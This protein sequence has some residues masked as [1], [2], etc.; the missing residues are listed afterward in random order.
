MAKGQTSTRLCT[1][2]LWLCPQRAQAALEN[3]NVYDPAEGDAVYKSVLNS[4]RSASMN[5]YLFEARRLP[6]QHAGCAALPAEPVICQTWESFCCPLVTT[7][8]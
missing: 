1:L 2:S 3:L 4:V 5:C 6:C 7:N 8:A